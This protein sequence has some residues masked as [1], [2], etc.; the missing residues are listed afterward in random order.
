MGHLS[1]R[2]AQ[3]MIEPTIYRVAPTQKIGE[4]QPIFWGSTGHFKPLEY[5]E[6]Y[7]SIWPSPWIRKLTKI[8]QVGPMYCRIE[9]TA[10][11]PAPNIETDPRQIHPNPLSD[12]VLSVVSAFS[13]MWSFRRLYESGKWHWHEF[14]VPKTWR[15]IGNHWEIIGRPFKPPWDSNDARIINA[16]LKKG[17]GPAEFR[18]SMRP[19]RFPLRK[20]HGRPIVSPLHGGFSIFFPGFPQLWVVCFLKFLGTPQPSSVSTTVSG[21][22]PEILGVPPSHHPLIHRLFP[23]KKKQRFFGV[24]PWLRRDIL[25]QLQAGCKI[26]RCQVG[27]GDPVCEVE[28]NRISFSRGC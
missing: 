25:P 13:M 10:F 5:H 28:N 17:S 23:T 21:L 24:S 16:P 7:L 8:E 26:W 2:Y 18:R 14:T 27:T 1:G 20:S 4:W 12:N 3:L 15:I 11:V 6:I 9:E 22:F 19:G